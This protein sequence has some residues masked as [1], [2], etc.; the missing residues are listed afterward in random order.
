[1]TRTVS[2]P[3]SASARG[4]IAYGSTPR[5]CGW[6]SGNTARSGAGAD[7]TG[8]ASRSASATAVGQLPERSTPAPYTSTGLSLPART[9]AN[10]S[11]RC[12][13]GANRVATVRGAGSGSAGWAQSSIGRERKTGPAGGCT[14]VA[15]ARSTA[16]GMSCARAGS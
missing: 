2:W 11:S 15:Y 13:S 10:S 1:M 16:A 3:R 7:Q 14:A 12:G 4:P 9:R 5:K 6:S 8:A